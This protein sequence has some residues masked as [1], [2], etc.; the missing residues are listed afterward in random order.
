MSND[1]MN[2]GYCESCIDRSIAA[3]E[4]HDPDGGEWEME[5]DF[6]DGTGETTSARDNSG[7]ITFDCPECGGTG[8]C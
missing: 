8:W 5:C 6:C 4:E 7:R 1:C 3:A 2:C